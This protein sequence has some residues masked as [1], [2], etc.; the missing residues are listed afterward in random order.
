MTT[1]VTGIESNLT[2][3]RI[4]L[5]KNIIGFNDGGVYHAMATFGP[6][7]Y[8]STSFTI[9]VEGKYLHLHFSFA[10]LPF[11]RLLLDIVP[12]LL[13]VMIAVIVIVMIFVIVIVVAICYFFL[14]LKANKT[15][16]NYKTTIAF[17]CSTCSDKRHTVTGSLLQTPLTISL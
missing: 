8:N 13:V 5:Y 4:T 6:M 16:T 11:L 1:E 17:Y 9:K 10:P 2:V 7:Q 12:V 3:Y 14:Q 15:N